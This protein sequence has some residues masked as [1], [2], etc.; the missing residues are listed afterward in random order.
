MEW[1]PIE[2]AP[3]DG[4]WVLLCGGKTTEE[5]DSFGDIYQEDIN[6]PVVA[7]WLAYESG[8]VICY[9]DIGWRDGYNNPSHWAILPRPPQE[10]AKA[11]ENPTLQAGTK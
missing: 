4:T 7:K 3:K 11:H 5:L 1:L 2:S 10:E 8:W 9:W 6:R